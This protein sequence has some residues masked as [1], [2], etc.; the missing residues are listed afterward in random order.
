MAL[1]GS[2]K[3]FGLADILQLICFQRKSGIL[4]LEGRMDK[5]RMLFLDGN[6]V[7]AESK[8]RMEDNRIGKILLKKNVIKEADLQIALEE[9]RTTG[10]KLGN[11]LINMDL[12]KKEVIKEILKNQITETVIQVFGWKD[13]TYEFTAQGVPP[14]KEF[15]ISLDTQHLLMEGLRIVDE[16]SQIKGK[17]T[18]DTIFIKKSESPS[19]LTGEEEEIFSCVDGE[20][21]VSTIIDI[22]GL[23]NFQVSKTL[24][25]LMEKGVIEA[26][27]EVPLVVS[28]E[29]VVSTKET[30][31]FL[32][33]LPVV[34]IIVSMLISI[35]VVLLQKQN[36]IKEFRASGMIED[37]RVSIETYKFEHSEYPADLGLISNRKDPWG[38]PFIYRIKNGLFYLIS[39][40]ADGQEG[41]EDDIY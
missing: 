16:W 22:S 28:E 30:P 23:D 35:S 2:L 40:G 31:S 37:L 38:R 34:V 9:Q 27:E 6:I 4:V 18:L 1:E 26:A 20:N 41:T 10:N 14:D 19:G 8:R 32:G 11:I 33:Y 24:L 39:V 12:V 3:D 5:V 15:L 29:V 13:G 17:L 36:I 21:D 25:S 7:S